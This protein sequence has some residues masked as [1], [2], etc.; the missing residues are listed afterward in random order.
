MTGRRVGIESAWGCL[1][2]PQN[3]RIELEGNF[4]GHLVHLP[5]IEQGQLQLRQ[6]AQ[7]LHQPELGCLQ[8]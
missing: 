3:Q 2:G 8:G 5:C 1:K 6:V 4:K 7:S